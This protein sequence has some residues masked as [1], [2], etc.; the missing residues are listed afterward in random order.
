MGKSSFYCNRSIR[1]PQ[2]SN[3][4]FALT[5]LRAAIAGTG[6]ER[7]CCQ[8]EVSQSWRKDI[9]QTVRGVPDACPW[10]ATSSSLPLYSPNVGSPVQGASYLELR[11]C[12]PV[13]FL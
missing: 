5:S 11:E 7:D 4:R 1:S 8:G 6:V 13:L 3:Y 2:G 12:G 10:R 9:Q